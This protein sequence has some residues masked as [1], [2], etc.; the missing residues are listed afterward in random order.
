MNEIANALYARNNGDAFKRV[1][2]TES[3]DE[4][5]NGKTRLTR[6]VDPNNH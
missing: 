6:Q 3:H 5:A 2:Y 4:T 1:I